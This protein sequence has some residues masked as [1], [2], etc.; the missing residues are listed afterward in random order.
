VQTTIIDPEP[1]VY[2]KYMS[3]V[4]LMIGPEHTYFRSKNKKL[5]LSFTGKIALG[6]LTSKS[7]AT[8]GYYGPWNP[9]SGSVVPQFRINTFS[10][11]G[12][13]SCSYKLSPKLSMKL[14]A[15]GR[16]FLNKVITGQKN[17]MFP[18]HVFVGFGYSLG[19]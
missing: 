17:R 8:V 11:M 14:D 18:L 4:D 6:L 3:Y 9:Y 13:H 7:D 10:V 1:L 12:K 15:G 5:S 2:R 16:I 19:L